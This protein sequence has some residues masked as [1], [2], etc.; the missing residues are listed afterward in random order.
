MSQLHNNIA[1]TTTLPKQL[2]MAALSALC[3]AHAHYT[4]RMHLT[5]SF[6]CR[7]QLEALP[8]HLLPLPLL[9]LPAPCTQACVGPMLPAGRPSHSSALYDS[10][11]TCTCGRLPTELLRDHT[12]CCRTGCCRYAGLQSRLAPCQLPAAA[13]E[14]PYTLLML[15]LWRCFVW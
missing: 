7:S 6:F 5:S 4:P 8:P 1:S 12:G 10:H 2:A 11:D 13:A 14:C 9:L 3:A 15:L